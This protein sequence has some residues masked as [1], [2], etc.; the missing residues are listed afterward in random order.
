MFCDHQI[1]IACR[2][3]CLEKNALCV[4]G[5]RFVVAK[6]CM[7]IPVGSP[8]S[9]FAADINLLLILILPIIIT[10][11]L[12][13]SVNVCLEG[14]EPITLYLRITIFIALYDTIVLLQ[15]I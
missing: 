11:H 13:I 5:S 14:M 8:L 2:L 15:V 3:H 7:I 1:I 12:P 9:T 10:P 6:Y 4:K